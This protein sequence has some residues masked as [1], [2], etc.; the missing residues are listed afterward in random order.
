VLTVHIDKWHASGMIL[1][2]DPLDLSYGT[3][4]Y[5]SYIPWDTIQTTDWKDGGLK[6]GQRLECIHAS[7]TGVNN[8]TR[9]LKFESSCVRS[10]DPVVQ[11]FDMRASRNQGTYNALTTIGLFTQRFP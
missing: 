5:L 7:V 10:A 6:R 3:G 9:V 2:V 8:R 11:I 4:E 1:R